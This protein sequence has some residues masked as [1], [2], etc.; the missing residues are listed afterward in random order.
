[1][2]DG[3]MADGHRTGGIV[4]AGP[5]AD[6]RP[7]RPVDL[8]A[9][10]LENR[11]AIMA[12]VERV[13]TE[14]KLV[15]GP[16]IAL[17]EQEIAA[18]CGVRHCIALNS[19]TDALLFAMAALGIG[20]GDE[21][22]VPTNSFV[23]SAA[24]VA[25]LG[26]VPVFC[27]VADDQNLDPAD[28]ARRITPRT[29]AIMPVHLTGRVADM[30]A[31]TALAARHGLLVVEDAAQAFGSMRDG[32]HAGT[33]GDA[34]CFS[35]HP[36][37]NLNAAGDSGYITT[38][39]DDVAA[40]VRAYRNHGMVDRGLAAAWG[41]VS[42]M[43]T[44]QAALLRLKL[45]GL[46]D[47]IRRRRRNADLYRQ[48][49][50]PAVVFMPPEAA[51]VFHSYHLFVIQVARRDALQAALQA[52]GIGSSVHYP[53]PIHLQPAAA[54]LGWTAGD[55]PVAERQA[56][57]ILSLPI[58]Q[59]LTVADIDRVAAAVNGFYAGEHG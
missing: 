35:A 8:G 20:R 44:L 50:D 52:Q 12:C 6:S 15:G 10:F 33:F 17:L 54:A 24:A 38:D 40:A 19:G 47:V 26:A 36:L 3:H 29:R 9:Q 1:M 14:G 16:D 58:H 51:G 37:K 39:R 42:R 4:D 46:P 28:V 21:V 41:F 45:P 31:I 49:L 55:L 56:T 27:D 2:A 59:T 53:T 32:R 25:H 34:G 18:F 22:I 43:D 48:R 11:D 57:R 5:A 30:A 23:A 13:L 7:I